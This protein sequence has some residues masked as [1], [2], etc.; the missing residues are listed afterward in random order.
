VN[1]LHLVVPLISICSI[2]SCLLV[3]SLSGSRFIVL[4]HNLLFRCALSWFTEHIQSRT[5]HIRC[6]LDISAY[7]PVI[8]GPSWFNLFKLVEFQI[9]L[10]IQ[11]PPPLGNFQWSIRPYPIWSRKK[12]WPT[13]S[14]I[15]PVWWTG[16]TGWT[17]GR[18]GIYTV[19]LF[20]E[21]ERGGGAV[22]PR[23][24]K[25]QGCQGG[26]QNWQQYCGNG[27]L[28]QRVGYHKWLH[29]ESDQ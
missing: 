6:L 22:C 11:P 20:C 16:Q 8:S 10:P 5:I 19:E 3:V 27:G 25:E 17:T 12:G 28:L 14:S 21:G 15:K 29:S 4:V 13:P 7:R 1:T 23:R 26:S 9:W 18:T 24:W 2:V